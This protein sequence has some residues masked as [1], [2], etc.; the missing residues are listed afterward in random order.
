MKSN[1]FPL[2]TAAVATVSADTANTPENAFASE[3]AYGGGI[4]RFGGCDTSTDDPSFRN[5]DNVYQLDMASMKWTE[6]EIQ[7]LHRFGTTGTSE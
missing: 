2:L 3:F 4:Y 6:A 1:L 5:L 7:R